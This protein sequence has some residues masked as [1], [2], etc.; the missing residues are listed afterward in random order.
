M[1][2]PYASLVDLK[3]RLDITMDFSDGILEQ[4]IEAASRQIDG[5][6]ERTF[7]VVE[8]PR[9]VTADNLGMVILPWDLLEA[10]SI[11]VDPYGDG[12]YSTDWSLDSVDMQPYPGP[13]QVI[14][15][16]MGYGFPTHRHGVQV[17]GS[18]GYANTVP[19]AIYEATLLEATRLF[20]RKDA[21]FGVAGNSV[22]GQIQTITRVDP[23]V[24]EL[25][26]PY[27]RHRMVV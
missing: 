13:V 19:A 2:Q 11:A 8:E 10:T 26:Q 12:S 25:I 21:P 16:R 27:I 20:K 15:T 5:W 1:S 9:R 14:K 18:W 23:D 24:R 4:V 17:S 7:Y 22:H 6:C 3:A